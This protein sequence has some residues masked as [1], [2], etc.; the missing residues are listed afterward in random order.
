MS[1]QKPPSSDS[2]SDAVVSEL[3]NVSSL[4][5]GKNNCNPIDSLADRQ[6]EFSEFTQRALNE[7][8]KLHQSLNASSSSRQNIDQYH[9]NPQ[10]P[11]TTA[12]PTV[13]RST[14]PIKNKKT[15][16]RRGVKEVQPSLFDEPVV[17]TTPVPSPVKQIAVDQLIDQLVA[18]HLPQIEQ[19][20]RAELK[21][22]LDEL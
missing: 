1:E 15:K 8:E 21:R 3:K 22:L 19:K 2:T 18:E 11:T 16:I 10:K 4:L 5:R 7:L 12:R 14:N 20:L 6:L 13:P 9:N 17:E